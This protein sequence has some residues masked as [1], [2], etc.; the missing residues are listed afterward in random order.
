[1]GASQQAGEEMQHRQERE[2][3]EELALIR[4]IQ[5]QPGDQRM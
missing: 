4:A 2:K 3:T 1:M 5:G